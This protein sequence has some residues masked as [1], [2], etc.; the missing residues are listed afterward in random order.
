MRIFAYIIRISEII[1]LRKVVHLLLSADKPHIVATDLSI[2][3]RCE[4]SNSKYWLSTPVLDRRE[5]KL[6]GF[7]YVRHDRFKTEFADH[8]LSAH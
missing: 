3:A 6:R 4:S 1:I 2:E 8:G 5:D 7:Y